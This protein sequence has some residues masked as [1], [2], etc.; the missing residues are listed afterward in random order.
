MPNPR[1]AARYAKSLI[2]LAQEKGQLN[3]VYADMQYLNALCKGSREFVNLLASPIIN[4]HKKNAIIAVVTSGKVSAITESFNKLLV[5]KGREADLVEIVQA[6][7]NQ[8]NAINNIRTVQLTTA[9]AISDNVK[10]N[11]ESKV[12]GGEFT[13][14]I[15]LETKVNENLIGG[16]VLEFDNQ[17]VDTSVSNAL[18][19]IKKQFND[20][21]FINKMH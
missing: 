12:K 2:D 8:Y 13:G 19:N 1:L 7:I 16:F 21:Q 10:K 20:N 15:E 11:I 17:I 14:T 18:K 9:V 3:V 4:A 5:N 6:F